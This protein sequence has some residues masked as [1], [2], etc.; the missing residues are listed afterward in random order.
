MKMNSLHIYLHHLIHP[1]THQVYTHIKVRRS[2]NGA[3]FTPSGSPSH[4]PKAKSQTPEPTHIHERTADIASK[5]S[6]LDAQARLSHISPILI[7]AALK[8][9][10]AR[11]VAGGQHSI[12]ETRSS[13]FRYT[14]FHCRLCPVPRYISLNMMAEPGPGHG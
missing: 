14:D 10:L 2:P 8:P 13:W 6:A 9:E 5:V 3:Q 4:P 7:S 11:L 1:P 12:M